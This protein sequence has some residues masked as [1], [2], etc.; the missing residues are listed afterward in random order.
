MIAGPITSDAYLKLNKIILSQNPSPK[1]I[2]IGHCVIGSG[3][4]PHFDNSFLTDLPKRLNIQELIVGCPP[5]PMQIEKILT[6]YS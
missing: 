1:L 3:V 2:G 4:W 6:K 5:H